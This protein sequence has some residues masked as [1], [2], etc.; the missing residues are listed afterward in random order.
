MEEFIKAIT[1][2]SKFVDKNRKYPI[3]CEHDVLYVWGVNFD[4]MTADDVRTL[5]G[6][7]FAIGSSGDFDETPNW[8]SI[9]EAEWQKIKT[10][11]TKCVHSY[12]WGSC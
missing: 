12:L 3:N 7:G 9:S 5:D 1:F 4:N 2:L 11:A 6:F 10:S 8:A